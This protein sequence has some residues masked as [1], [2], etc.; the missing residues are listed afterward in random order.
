MSICVGLT[1]CNKF[2]MRIESFANFVLIA[3]KA[4]DSCRSC[5]MKAACGAESRLLVARKGGAL[6]WPRT[7]T[8]I[9]PRLRST[10]PHHQ[11]AGIS[12][13]GF[14]RS[15]SSSSSSSL[16]ASCH[17]LALPRCRR[18]HDSRVSHYHHDCHHHYHHH[19]KE[20]ECPAW[21]L[22]EIGLKTPTIT[23][24]NRPQHCTIFLFERRSTPKPQTLNPNPKPYTGLRTVL[25]SQSRP[26]L[27]VRPSQCGSPGC[28]LQMLCMSSKR[29]LFRV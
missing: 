16:S 19:G 28:K 12:A 10:F 25:R 15:C 3:S 17:N 23:V 21:Y 27:C 11:G 22:V 9:D 13:L 4:Q 8:V 7:Q 2:R 24:R 20:P 26:A 5:I 1:Q 18:H 14:P 29:F 6:V